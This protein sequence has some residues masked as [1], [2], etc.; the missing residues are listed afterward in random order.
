MVPEWAAILFSVAFVVS[1]HPS[2]CTP[3]LIAVCLS[4]VCVL[5]LQL[6]FGEIVPQ[7]L[8]SHNPLAIGAKLAPL[9]K[10][11]LVSHSFISFIGLIADSFGH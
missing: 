6:V 3:L 10:F 8:C 2:A 4:S 1:H 5:L 9:V 11:F 7:A